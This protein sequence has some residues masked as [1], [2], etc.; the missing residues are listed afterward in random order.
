MHFCISCEFPIAV[1]GRVWPCLHVFCLSCAAD[2]AKC[3][4]CRGIVG[5]IERIPCEQGLFVSAA[6]LQG[7]RRLDEFAEHAHQVQAKLTRG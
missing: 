2:M 6:T 3:L 5:K 1:Y 7:F 4:V